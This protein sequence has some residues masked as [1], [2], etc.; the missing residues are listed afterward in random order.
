M[1]VRRLTDVV[2]ENAISII[3][4]L[5][6]DILI[7]LFRKH[8]ID[9]QWRHFEATNPFMRALYSVPTLHRD[10]KTRIRER[11]LTVISHDL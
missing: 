5:S 9:I 2:C 3:T 7:R 8:I 10:W 4:S 11:G 1:F 6:I